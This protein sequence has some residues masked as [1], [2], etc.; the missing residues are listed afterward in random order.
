MHIKVLRKLFKHEKK[1]LLHK[2]PSTN[3]NFTYSA[4]LRVLH[5]IEKFKQMGVILYHRS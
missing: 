2:S 1:T 4:S 3:I 5:D